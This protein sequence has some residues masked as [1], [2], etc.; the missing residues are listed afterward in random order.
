MKLVISSLIVSALSLFV[1]NSATPASAAVL[2]IP[3][4]P[5]Q[6]TIT[7]TS[8]V[9]CSCGGSHGN[10]ASSSIATPTTFKHIVSSKTRAPKTI[11]TSYGVP[12]STFTSEPCSETYSTV[13]SSET[14]VAT[15]PKGT[16]PTSYTSSAPIAA[17]S[18][19]SSCSTGPVHCCNSV[20]PASSE[21]ASKIVS[22]LGIVL[23]DVDVPVGLDCTPINILGVGSG[24]TCNA[25]TVCCEN[26]QFN[27]LINIGCSPINLPL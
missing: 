18:V 16:S 12:K 22:L 15:S 20:E 5:C 10:S 14:V 19:G 25:Q 2:Y 27:G 21:N 6:K 8:L 3:D 7:S 11:Y 13:S 9:T 23:Q 1:I 17:S 26:A 24:G 4:L